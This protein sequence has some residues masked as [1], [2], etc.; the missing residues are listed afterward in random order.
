[1]T[2][3]KMKMK[4]LVTLLVTSE[5]AKELF[6]TFFNVVESITVEDVND[7]YD[8]TTLDDIFDEYENDCDC[9]EDDCD[10]DDEVEDEE[11]DD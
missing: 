2:W 11:D 4:K 1:M 3:R 5:T 6:D 9:D 8:E 7:I 10:C